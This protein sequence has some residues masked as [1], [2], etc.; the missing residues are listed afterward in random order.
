MACGTGGGRR[1]GGRMTTAIADDWIIAKPCPKCG[2][3]DNCK[4]L[5]DGRKVWC[6]RVAE[7]AVETNA[8]GQHLHILIDDNGDAAP[9][10]SRPVT[11]TPSKR[12]ADVETRHT[13]YS[14]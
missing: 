9:K 3:S 4:I 8:G 11:A 13:A 1:Q 10:R 12:L 5:R 2:R 14:A 7:G 6:G